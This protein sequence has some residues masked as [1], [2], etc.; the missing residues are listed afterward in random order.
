MHA[1]THGE[2]LDATTPIPR[3]FEAFMAVDRG[4]KRAGSQTSR[5][6]NEKAVST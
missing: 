3:M 6:R 1:Q 4:F 2:A 5:P